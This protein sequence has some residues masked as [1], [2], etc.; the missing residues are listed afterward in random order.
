MLINLVEFKVFFK[1]CYKLSI[2]MLLHD[3]QLHVNH[4]LFN[5]NPIKIYDLTKEN[6]YIID[7]FAQGLPKVIEIL[8][9]VVNNKGTIFQGIKSGVIIL[10]DESELIDKYYNNDE[11]KQCNKNK[12]TDLIQDSNE[13]PIKDINELDLNKNINNNVKDNEDFNKINSD[14]SNYNNEQYSEKINEDND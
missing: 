1:L 12:E 9:P 11:I 8:P 4:N 5:A 6:C 7:G 13:I 10:P 2:F 3:P 14:K